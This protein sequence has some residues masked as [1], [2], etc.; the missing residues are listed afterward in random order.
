MRRIF[1]FLAC[2]GALSLAGCTSESAL[3]NPTGKG[4]VRAI[5]AIPGAT[6]VTFRIEER[7]LG[8]INYGQ[9]SPPATYDDFEYNFNFDIFVPASRD[10][11]RIA[12][13]TQKVDADRE[14]VF[15]L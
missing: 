14:H 2:I 4:V 15:A 11:T 13:V 7:T 8:N 6:S 10:A 1:V 5:H 3:P 12:S 9:A